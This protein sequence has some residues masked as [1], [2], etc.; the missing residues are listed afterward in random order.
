MNNL[1]AHAQNF[2]I[3]V[4]AP[5]NSHEKPLFDSVRATRRPSHKLCRACLPQ[6]KIGRA[7]VVSPVLVSDRA[8]DA[9]CVRRVRVGRASVVEPFST[10]LGVADTSTS[11]SEAILRQLDL[12]EGPAGRQ[13]LTEFDGGAR[14]GSGI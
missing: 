8:S 13:N 11:R 6:R 12:T 9:R 10:G 5:L 4:V 2:A 1:I 3:A 14:A 7:A